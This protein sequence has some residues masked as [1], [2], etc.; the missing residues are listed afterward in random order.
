MFGEPHEILP[1]ERERAQVIEAERDALQSACKQAEKAL[2]DLLNHGVV[3]NGQRY[4]A[5]PE[6]AAD[7]L[8]TLS[9]RRTK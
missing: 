2:R 5:H 8:R 9:E 3:F 4:E 1:R 7:A 6:W